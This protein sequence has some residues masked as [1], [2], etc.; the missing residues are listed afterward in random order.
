MLIRA[1]FCSF[2]DEGVDSVMEVE[3]GSNCGY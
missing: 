1:E 2:V 3:M